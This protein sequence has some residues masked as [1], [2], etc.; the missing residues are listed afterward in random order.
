MKTMRRLVALAFALAGFSGVCAVSFDGTDP[1]PTSGDVEIPKGTTVTVSTPEQ[2]AAVEGWTSVTFLGE[3]STLAF[4][5]GSGV[6]RLNAVLIG[7]GVVTAAGSAGLVIAADNRDFGGLFDFTDSAVTVASDYGLGGP[8]NRE[9]TKVRFSKSA[10]VGSLNFHWEGQKAFTNHCAILYD[11][12]NGYTAADGKMY[13]GSIAADE[14]FVQDADFFAAY[15]NGT[16]YKVQFRNNYEQISGTFGVKDFS[17]YFSTGG[18]VHAVVKFTGTTGFS[19]AKSNG[20]TTSWFILCD[21]TATYRFASTGGYVGGSMPVN[22]GTV[23]LDGDDPFRPIAGSA[24]AY[25][26]SSI[27]SYPQAQTTWKNLIDLNGHELV[28]NKLGTYGA[29]TETASNYGRIT[30]TSDEPGLI[31][32]VGNLNGAAVDPSAYE[33]T[34]KLSLTVDNNAVNNF[35]KKVADVT[36][37][38]TVKSGT[39]IYKWK[40]GWNGTA[41]VIDGGTIDA[42][43]VEAF[44]TG[45]PTLTI[46]SGSLKLHDGVPV[47]F[48]AAEIGGQ[49]LDP[50]DYTV[51]QLRNEYGLGAYVT[52]DD[53]AIL[54]VGASG[55]WT[56]WPDEEGGTAVVPKN[57]AVTVT[58]ADVTKVEKLGRI[59]LG[60]GSTVT[61]ANTTRLNLSA[62]LSGMGTFRIVDNAAGVTIL[63]DNSKLASPGAFW[64]ENSN[65]AVSNQFGLGSA[66]TGAATV[67]FGLDR[68]LTFGLADSHHFTNNVAIQY[69]GLAADSKNRPYIFFGSAS[70]DDYLVQ[71]ADFLHQAPGGASIL[72][73]IYFQNNVEF[74]SG[75]FGTTVDAAFSSGIKDAASSVRFSGSTFVCIGNPAGAGQ[76][77]YVYGSGYHWA[78]GGGTH[79]GAF[80]HDTGTDFIEADGLFAEPAAEYPSL[81]WKSYAQT[82]TTYQNMLD[83]GGHDLVVRGI[84]SAS[85][86]TEA[87]TTYTRATSATPATMT[88]VGNDAAVSN[89]GAPEF[90]G[91]VSVTVD[92]N[93]TNRFVHKV[94]SPDG[95]LTVR[96]GTLVYQWKG[97]WDG[98]ATA[99]EGGTLVCDCPEAF[100]GGRSTLSVTG[101][102]LELTANCPNVFFASAT[103]GG[104]TL[105]LD[106]Y[107]FKTLREQ[108]GLGEYLVG[109][110]AAEL[111]VIGEAG[112]WTGWPTEPGATAKI[113]RDRTVTI[114]DADLANVAQLGKIELGLNSKLVCANTAALAIA[115]PISGY[116]QI[117]IVDN[118]A[119]VTLLGD[120]SRLVS[121]GAFWIEN[122]NVAVSNRFGL[123]S[124]RTGAATVY[125]GIDRKLTFGLGDSNSFTNNV[126]I[127]YQAVASAGSSDAVCYFG[128]ASTDEYLVQNADFLSLASTVSYGKQAPRPTGNVEFL[129][130]FG[131]ST[132]TTSTMYIIAASDAVIRFGKTCTFVTPTGDKLNVWLY[133]AQHPHGARWIYDSDNGAQMGAVS[134]NIGT[135]RPGRENAWG[136]AATT[137]T[138]LYYFRNL[139]SAWYYQSILDL[140]GK[141]VAC[142]SF[143][144]QSYEKVVD[145]SDYTG[146]AIVTSGVASVLTLA[147]K[148]AMWRWEPLMFRGAAGF[149]YAGVGTNL[150]VGVTS[151]STGS[152][153]VSSGV[154][155]FDWGAKWG[156]ADITVDGTGT[157]YV[158][159][160]SA[161]VFGTKAE[162]K[163][164][165]VVLNLKDSGKLYLEG[166]A[167]CVYEA[168]RGDGSHIARG[169]Y[170]AANCDWIEGEGSLRIL[171][172]DGGMLL[173]VR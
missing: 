21:G 43:C 44:K 96:S 47:S 152:Y 30:N 27:Q 151:D 123:G 150:F 52:G 139:Q 28:M 75:T 109:D 136:D 158:G 9:A 56:G 153:R 112:E 38:L 83:L 99:I 57:A 74:I 133:G 132:G 114:T 1:W 170:T 48:A 98:T 173:L 164:K 162:V 124:F 7:K 140:D 10:T 76:T 42:Q 129:G 93:A 113:P 171:H 39:V 168:F 148:S 45:K 142:N 111:C 77:W 130:K 60:L 92:N 72:Q 2:I 127:K 146:C 4:A 58:E 166:G 25:G 29:D 117:R 156:G 79:I 141:N 95:T 67:Y 104:T 105:E 100:S 31:S 138:Q 12:D 66:K 116:G 115:C 36:G 125:F 24:S 35:T 71:N 62:A 97:G 81:Y 90:S 49:E 69:K 121:P 120:N 131:L 172:D 110:D 15:A 8:K 51:A 154:S 32:L 50:A 11:C 106:S 19:I 126:A 78:H 161:G 61:C 88:L 102:K 34:G 23:V 122:S 147:A 14:Y 41:V 165:K 16:A 118:A 13:L 167:N 59:V 91:K 73:R 135:V 22:V 6:A 53:G 18:D 54:S 33:L 101:G 128:S 89:L 82:Q 5:N 70:S 143:G 159:A 87:N 169:T 26:L 145:R 107:T 134:W 37:A 149:R 3:G 65:V 160:E 80:Q 137:L 108:Y 68:A 85:S 40:G 55:E 119:G 163:A 157:L 46:A 84:S 103:I 64:I 155:G 63:G 94:S 20:S 144:C 17:G 86:L